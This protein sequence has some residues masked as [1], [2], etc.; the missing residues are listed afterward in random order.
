MK[1]RHTN[2]WADGPIFTLFSSLSCL[3]GG[4]S[5]LVMSEEQDKCLQSMD[6]HRNAVSVPAQWES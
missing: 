6:L 1:Q 2:A 3:G 4:S 5:P